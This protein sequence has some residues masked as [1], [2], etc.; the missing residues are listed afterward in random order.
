ME[1]AYRNR[2]LDEKFRAA[3][4]RADEFHSKLMER[5]D[6]FEEDVRNSL[7]RIEMQTSKTNGRVNALEDRQGELQKW[8][9]YVLGF[10]ACLTILVVPI[11]I[12]IALKYFS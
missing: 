12:A 7:T 1:E 3:D 10:C 5:M 11:L 2:E 9:S 6:V 8:Q 4:E